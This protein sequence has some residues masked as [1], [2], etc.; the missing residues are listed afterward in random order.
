LG[1]EK[2][3]RLKKKNPGLVAEDNIMVTGKEERPRRRRREN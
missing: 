2:K 3:K 1:V